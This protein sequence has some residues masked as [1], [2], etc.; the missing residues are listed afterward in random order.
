MSGSLSNGEMQSVWLTGSL[1][2]AWICVIRDDGDRQVPEVEF[3]STCDDVDV[4]I[5][6][7]GD[8]CFLSIWTHSHTNT[9]HPQLQGESVLCYW[10]QCD[11]N[12]THPHRQ[13]LFGSRDGTWRHLANFI[14]F[15][16]RENTVM[17]HGAGALVLLCNI[18]TSVLQASV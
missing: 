8:V 1:D 7:H 17:L 12:C 9:F 14:L 6:V 18:T 15:W 10:K 11:G 2:E 13:H 4:F 3:K 5:D 16:A